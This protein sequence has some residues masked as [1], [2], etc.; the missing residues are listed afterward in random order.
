MLK[1]HLPRV[2][3]HQVYNVYQ[4]NHLL[5][6]RGY[7][8]KTE[9]KWMAHVGSESAFAGSG[10]KKGIDATCPT[11]R[12]RLIFKAQRLLYLS[13]LGSRVIKKEKKPKDQLAE[14][15]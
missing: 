8:S 15:D 5:G 1:G 9:E 14:S 6:C 4:N 10:C 2:A 11:F 13:T 12:G 7:H 3:H